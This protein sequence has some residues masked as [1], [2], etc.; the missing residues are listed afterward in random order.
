MRT[1]GMKKPSEV[2][3]QTSHHK[4]KH[5]KNTEFSWSHT[6]L[7]SL[8]TLLWDESNYSLLKRS[9][10][11]FSEDLWIIQLGVVN[12]ILKDLIHKNAIGKAHRF[13]APFLKGWNIL[14]LH[15]FNV[16]T[17]CTIT[18]RFFYLTYNRTKNI[19]IILINHVG[20][21]GCHIGFTGDLHSQL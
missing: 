9:D 20:M 6:K 18:Y 13:F 5:N 17:S 3:S 21:C 1:T 2:P 11:F 10:P 4:H 12:K 7:D 16:L 15:W 14:Y 8:R 19:D